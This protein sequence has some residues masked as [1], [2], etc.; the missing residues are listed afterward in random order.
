MI[1]HFWMIK[2]RPSHNEIVILTEVYFLQNHDKHLVVYILASRRNNDDAVLE[3]SINRS[4]RWLAYDKSR[5]QKCKTGE[6]GYAVRSEAVP[7]GPLQ[8]E[9]VI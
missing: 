1:T 6:V 4:F 9:L 2:K 5:A 7:T 3:T 8:K